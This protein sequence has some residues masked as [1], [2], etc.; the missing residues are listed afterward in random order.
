MNRRYAIPPFALFKSSVRIM[1]AIFVTSKTIPQFQRFH[2]S[3]T[4]RRPT[5]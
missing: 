5:R 4:C 3:S 1:A 2:R